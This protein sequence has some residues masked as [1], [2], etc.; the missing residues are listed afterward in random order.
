MGAGRIFYQPQAHN[1]CFIIM[2]SRDMFGRELQ[3]TRYVMY[4]MFKKGEIL[5]T[6]HDETILTMIQWLI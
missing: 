5:L 1:L 2:S 6:E 3:K 4:G